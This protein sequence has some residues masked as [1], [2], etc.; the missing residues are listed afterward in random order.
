VDEGGPAPTG[1]GW[2]TQ[3]C[4]P[5]DA[6]SCAPGLGCGVDFLGDNVTLTSCEAVVEP[7]CASDP[8][9]EGCMY[10][11]C[12]GSARCV[13]GTDCLDTLSVGPTPALCLP[14]CDESGACPADSTCVRGRFSV[15]YH[16]GNDAFERGICVPSCTVGEG[17]CPTP[18]EL[19]ISCDETHP[20]EGTTALCT[21]ACES[22]TDCFEA[23]FVCDLATHL[24]TRN[25]S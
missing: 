11:P 20:I 24:C 12:T 7:D 19:Q 23:L 16:I 14:Y 10:Q 1:F 13:A 8:S 5:A 15:H 6:G 3:P 18:D 9:L 22:N 25:P 2:C 17:I 21:Q 4:D